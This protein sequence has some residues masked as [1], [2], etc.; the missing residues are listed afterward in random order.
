MGHPLS[1]PGGRE[2]ATAMSAP[3]PNPEQEALIG[4][5]SEDNISTTRRQAGVGPCEAKAAAE[6]RGYHSVS[7]TFCREGAPAPKLSFWE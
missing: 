7:G 3:A 2:H 6:R 1:T 5:G 4:H